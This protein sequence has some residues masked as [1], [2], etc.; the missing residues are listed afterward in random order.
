MLRVLSQSL[1]LCE[2]LA[3]SSDKSRPHSIRI[4]NLRLPDFAGKRQFN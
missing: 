4:V 2:I 3:M 1:D